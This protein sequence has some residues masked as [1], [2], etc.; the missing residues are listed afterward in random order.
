MKSCLRLLKDS[1]EL[2]V[3][4]FK[5][6]FKM[7]IEYSKKVIQYFKNPKF[8]RIPKHVNAEAKVGNIV[9]GDEIKIFLYIENGKIEDIGYK[10]FGCAAAIASSE[11]LCRLV[12]GKSV[13]EAKKITPKKI[14]EHLGKL[15]KFKYHCLTMVVQALKNAI[16]NYEKLS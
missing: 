10:T 15:P 8:A 16:E 4:S 12:K 5:L 2:A 11:A 9:C 6:S 7:E 1:G 13:K 14:L 3:L